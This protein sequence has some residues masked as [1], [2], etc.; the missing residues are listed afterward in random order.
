M[1]WPYFAKRTRSLS[2]KCHKMCWNLI[3]RKT[4]GT[5][6]SGPAFA[7][8]GTRR[9]EQCDHPKLV[10]REMSTEVSWLPERPCPTRSRCL[11]RG[12]HGPH[13]S[14]QPPTSQPSAN[15]AA[16]PSPQIK[17]GPSFWP[18]DPRASSSPGLPARALQHT[19]ATGLPT[20]QDER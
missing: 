6:S 12:W 18:Q 11:C 9:P 2:R 13:H 3:G 20:A 16:K 5:S 19:L 10:A 14:I 7:L 17:P 15:L 8:M 1:P 4:T